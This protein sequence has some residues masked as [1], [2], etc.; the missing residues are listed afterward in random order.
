[1]ATSLLTLVVPVVMLLS[2]C[3]GYGHLSVDTRGASGDA[4]VSVFRIWPPLC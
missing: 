3:L 1:M 2:L 4:V